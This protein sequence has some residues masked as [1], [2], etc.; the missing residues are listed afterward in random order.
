MDQFLDKESNMKPTIHRGRLRRSING[1]PTDEFQE[2]EWFV[3]LDGKL[4]RLKFLENSVPVAE[5]LVELDSDNNSG[6]KPKKPKG[7]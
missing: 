5:N 6:N 2:P 4:H 1:T 7:N 3:R